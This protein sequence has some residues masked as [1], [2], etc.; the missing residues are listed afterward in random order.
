M[1]V[2]SSNKATKIIGQRKTFYRQG[3]P[4]SSSVRRETVDIEIPV[5]SRNGD[6]KIMQFIRV[7]SR[8][9][10]SASSVSFEEHLPK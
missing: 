3:I 8:P 5:T 1:S 7:N 9:A 4:E 10:G 6:R 2:N